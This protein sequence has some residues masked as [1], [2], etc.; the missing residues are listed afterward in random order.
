MN[1]PEGE[2]TT[3]ISMRKEYFCS[4]FASITPVS[5]ISNA[6]DLSQRSNYDYSVRVRLSLEFHQ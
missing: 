6:L 5:H 4:T 1:K 2:I 3:A